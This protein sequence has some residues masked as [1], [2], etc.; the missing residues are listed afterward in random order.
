MQRT[1]TS[2]DVDTYRPPRP[3]PEVTGMSG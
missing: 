1:G 2:V 3:T